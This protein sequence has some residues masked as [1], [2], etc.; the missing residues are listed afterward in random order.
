MGRIQRLNTAKTEYSEDANTQRALLYLHIA[1]FIWGFTGVL[2]RAIELNALVLVVYRMLVTALIY[3]VYFWLMGIRFLEDR[4]SIVRLGT[5]GFIMGV[6]WVAFYG[7]IKLANI[8]VA[9]ICL[10]TASVFTIFIEAVWK[11]KKVDMR[12]LL[13]GIMA[14]VG[15]FLV[16]RDNVDFKQ[17]L[18]AGLIAAMLSGVFTIM[19][20]D[21]IEDYKASVIAFYEL[22]F[23][24]FLILVLV[25][26]SMATG[27]TMNIWPD[28]H[29]W[30]YLFLLC[31][32]CTFLGQMLA[33]LSLK[34]LTPFTLA[35]TVN[36]E[37]F[38]GILLA[39]FFY[40]EHKFIG[41]YFYLGS[42]LIILSVVLQSVW[43]YRGARL[44]KAQ[45]RNT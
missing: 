12:E 26:I 4:K 8:S 41:A 22:G 23:G 36:L 31:F 9:M 32:F 1:V 44:A 5:I 27:N 15:V 43:V 34:K 37:T 17:G 28:A 13:L 29:S 21:V 10:A 42:T 11:K 14:I 20:K 45:S 7:A 18:I 39:F 2:G 16:Y 35:L 19:N 30:W 38:Y 24:G 3:L 6:H 33:L 25:I 40:Q